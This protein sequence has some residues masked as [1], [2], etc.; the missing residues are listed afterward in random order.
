MVKSL[1][2]KL[3]HL[4][5]TWW[6]ERPRESQP[7]SSDGSPG[8]SSPRAA[9]TATLICFEDVFPHHVREYAEDDTDF[10]INLTNDGW[11]GEGAEQWQHAGSAVF[12]AVENGLPLLRCCNN[13]LTCWIDSRGRLQQVFRDEAG[14]IYGAGVMTAR[15]PV[16][17]PGETR[18][19]TF[20][21]RHGDWFGWSCVGAT[22]LLLAQRLKVRRSQVTAGSQS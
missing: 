3:T 1:C 14:R 5:L 20:Y 2:Q 13:G 6:S 19:P 15:I 18:D 22:A 10:L 8:V 7:G 17:S 12:R 4:L 11:F 21:N 16:L 9:K